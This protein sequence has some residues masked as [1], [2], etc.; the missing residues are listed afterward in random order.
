[1]SAEDS[2]I[3]LAETTRTCVRTVNEDEIELLDSKSKN[4]KLKSKRSF[5]L[6]LPSVRIVP[7][8]R[9]MTK[10][11]RNMSCVSSQE[12]DVPQIEVPRHKSID[13]GVGLARRVSLFLFTKRSV[14]IHPYHPFTPHQKTRKIYFG[15][16]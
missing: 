16:D 11:M 15:Y 4:K 7:S 10:R 2:L 6:R 14:C 12:D 5:F 13:I 9:K 8:F 1:M 3:A